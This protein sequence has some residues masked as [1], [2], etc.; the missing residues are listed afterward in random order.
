[1]RV[2]LVEWTLEAVASFISP[3]KIEGE[4]EEFKCE[5]I[6]EVIRGPLK[7][8]SLKSWIRACR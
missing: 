6:S 3:P 2:S 7:T 5:E 4:D 8:Y 1:M